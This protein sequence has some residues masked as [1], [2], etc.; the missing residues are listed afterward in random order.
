MTE[1][2]ASGESMWGSGVSDEAEDEKKKKRH[3]RREKR[4]AAKAAA[5]AAPSESD[6]E[7]KKETRRK[8]RE[9]RRATKTEVAADAS[10]AADT[11]A[12]GESEQKQARRERREKRKA[13]KLAAAGEAAS[14]AGEKNRR[15]KKKKK[16]RKAAREAAAEAA[17]TAKRKQKKKKQKQQQQKQQQQKKARQKEKKAAKPEKAANPEEAREPISFPLQQGSDEIVASFA[18]LNA[19]AL[20]GLQKHRFVVDVN[21]VAFHAY[22][23][24]SAYSRLFVLLGGEAPKEKRSEPHFE[25]RAWGEMLPGSV[26]W[27]SDPTLSLSDD[28]S[29]GWYVGTREKDYTAEMANLVDRIAADLDLSRADIVFYGGSGGGFAALMCARH[30]PGASCIVVNPQ[31]NLAKHHKEHRKKLAQFFSGETNFGRVA[32]EH[33]ERVSILAAFPTADSLPP[34][35][36]VQNRQDKHHF[37][38]HYALFCQTYSAPPDGGLSANGRVLT[39]LFEHGVGH[40]AEPRPMVRPLMSQALV[41]FDRFRKSKK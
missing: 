3:E 1:L 7:N 26:L 2:A 22:F 24:R 13:A 30:L 41:F 6:S 23:E 20:A 31:I 10:G 27:I 38:E 33:P 36:Y 11:P 34:M 19:V 9:L 15:N 16:K 29:L 25:R 21:G 14:A 28:I 35:V 8:R 32:N 12:E 17:A 5:N 40:V 39:L 4:R 37:D 18:A